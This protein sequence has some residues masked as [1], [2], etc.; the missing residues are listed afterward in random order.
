MPLYALTALL[1]GTLLCLSPPVAAVERIL[2]Y[3]SDIEIAEDASMT[4]TETI[5]VVAEGSQIRRGI[6]RDFPT[7]YRDRFGNKYVVGFKVLAVTR[8][9][10]QE[11]W[12]RKG[13]SNGARIYAGSSNI[14]LSPGTYTYTFTYRTNRQ[15]G[16]FENH[17]ELYW[18]VTGN[19]WDFPMDRVSATV[20]LPAA[21]EA[22]EI[23]LAGYTGRQDSKEQNYSSVVGELGGTIQATRPLAA[24]EGLTL[25][26]K[27]PKG[28]VQ[29]PSGMQRGMYL[30]GDNLGLVLS[31]LAFFGSGI[32][33]YQM[34]S[35]H[36]RDP[37]GGIVIPLYEPPAGYSP[38]SARYI[39]RMAY[40]NK[41]LTAALVNL[42]V[43]GHVGITCIDD[44]Y[45]LKRKSSA[46]ELA[47]GEAALLN[48][49]F[50]QGSVLVLENSNHAQVSVARSA[51]KAALRKDYLNTYFKK[52][53]ILL[54]PSLAVSLLLLFLI[55]VTASMVPLVA[56]V[57]VGI[58]ALHVLFAYLLKA[59]SKRGRLL[60]DKLDGF[61]LYLE[62]AEKDA[63][64]LRHPPEKTPELFEKYLPFAI[65]LGVEQA[66]AEQFSDVF[67][68]LA[69]AGGKS[70]SPHWYSGDFSSSR[71]NRFTSDV[72]NN[73]SSAISSAATPPGSSSGSGGGSSGGG[74]GGGGGGGW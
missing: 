72:S 8:D 32:Y 42:A 12:H 39:S 63:L 46:E 58:I 25:V 57:Y 17:D 21:L 74:G 47:P 56:V 11:P 30:L 13:R 4:V 52:N 41:T 48:K 37:Q 20:S 54:L 44:D 26:M 70:Y 68:R 62:V 27:W 38:A 28:L 69:A 7:T 35:R 14:D 3:H 50:R 29:A 45:S 34:W 36:G 1:L 40:D 55:L 19:G 53:G 6:Y 51:H 16:F 33:L 5:K 49:L 9:G 65:A 18:N 2:S 64:E 24:R 67:A 10:E 15:L 61:K 71:I 22:A 60:L 66:W 73:F 23:S 31:L 59:P 43:K